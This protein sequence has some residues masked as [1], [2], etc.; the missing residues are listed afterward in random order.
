MIVKNDNKDEHKNGGDND[1]GGSRVTTKIYTITMVA[2]A[3]NQWHPLFLFRGGGVGGDR[4][5]DDD[6]GGSFGFEGKR[7]PQQQEQQ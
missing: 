2:W 6:S 7:H 4:S 5:R 3:K 1:K